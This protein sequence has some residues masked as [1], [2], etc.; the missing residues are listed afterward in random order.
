MS[1]H[2]LMIKAD[3][4][5]ERSTLVSGFLKLFLRLENGRPRLVTQGKENHNDG[6]P[7]QA[8]D[9]QEPVH[10]ADAHRQFN[11]SH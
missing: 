4:L 8:R 3:L 5:C 7:V 6:Q 10:D 11:R 1:T 2:V 9:S